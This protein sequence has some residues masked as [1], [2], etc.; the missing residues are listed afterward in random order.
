MDCVAAVVV[1]VVVEFVAETFVVAPCCNS[2]YHAGNKYSK[3]EDA[4]QLPEYEV[5]VFFACVL[6]LCIQQPLY[7]C[8]LVNERKN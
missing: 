6:L 2:V 3:G 8:T 4:E 7:L 1:F 5:I